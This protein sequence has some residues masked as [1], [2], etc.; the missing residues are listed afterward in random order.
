MEL[1]CNNATF[2][3]TDLKLICSNSSSSEQ[4]LKFKTK[5]MSEIGA[6]NIQ[7]KVAP[8]RWPWTL[9]L[10][11]LEKH[12]WNQC[13]STCN[14]DASMIGGLPW[15]QTA[16]VPEQVVLDSSSSLPQS[17]S[18]SHSQRSG[19]QRLFLHLNLSVGQVCWSAERR[20][21][22]RGGKKEEGWSS[23]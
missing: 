18:P 1:N 8:A 15:I 7:L 4:K 22:I 14:K 5:T 16:C 11:K 10:S 2:T 20:S 3:C 9:E 17:L 23:E 12:R 6:H 19:M 13:R 21:C